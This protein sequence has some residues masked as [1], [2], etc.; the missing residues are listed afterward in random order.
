MTYSLRTLNS[1]SGT[2]ETEPQRQSSEGAGWLR[3]TQEIVLF[4]GASALLV[5]ANTSNALAPKNKT[6]SCVKRNQPAP[7]DDCLC[8]SV[9]GVP[10]AL[11]RV[12]SE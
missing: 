11:L 6:I 9:S 12:R 2:P 4:L 7:S 3:F 5:L 10:D 8:G 1:A